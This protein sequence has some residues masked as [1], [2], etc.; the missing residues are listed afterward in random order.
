MSAYGKSR[1]TAM[2]GDAAL[3]QPTMLAMRDAAELIIG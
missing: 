3:R 2:G 1:S